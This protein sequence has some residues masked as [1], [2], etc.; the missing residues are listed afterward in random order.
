M[1]SLTLFLRSAECSLYVDV[2]MGGNRTLRVGH[3]ASL[4]RNAI[5]YPSDRSQSCYS[6]P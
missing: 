5:A 6:K 4:I 1:S 2:G 3:E